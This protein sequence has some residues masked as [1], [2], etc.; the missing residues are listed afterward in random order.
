MN[1][2]YKKV[3]DAILRPPD[4]HPWLIKNKKNAWENGFQVVP[5]TV[6]PPKNPNSVNETHRNEIF[7]KF[8]LRAERERESNWLGAAP[9]TSWH[10]VCSSELRSF[11]HASYGYC[12]P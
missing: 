4:P 5:S 1:V 6:N 11:S 9:R 12:T 3:R 7:N 10:L 2:G 8:N